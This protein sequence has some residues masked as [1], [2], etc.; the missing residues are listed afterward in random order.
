MKLDKLKELVLFLVAIILSVFI[1]K[2][3]KIFTYL[4]LILGILVPLFVGFIYAWLL[5]PLINKLRKGHKR[6]FICIALFLV[7]ITIILLFFYLL[8]PTIYKEISELSDI[9]PSFFEIIGRKIN[10]LGLREY[11]DRGLAF[12]VDKI[13]L[14]LVNLVKGLFKY[15]GITLVGLILGLY[16]SMDYEKIVKMIDELVPQKFKCIYTNLTKDV[17]T[18]VRKC[19]N[20]TLLVA[21]CVFVMDSILFMI[22]GLD[23]SLLLGILCGITDLIPYIGPYIGGILAVCVGFTESR[24]LGIVTIII[25]VIVQSIENYILQPIVMSKSIKI[26]PVLII[27][28]LLLFGNLFGIVGMILAT[29]IIAIIKVCLEHLK[30]AINKCKE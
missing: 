16:I 21:F 8:I 4:K 19:V 5:N 30:L 23:A 14:Y 17:S 6:N 22:V 11:I 9:L 24:M 2:Y 10:N 1:I 25:C 12:L 3:L 26:S 7:I 29:P 20:G 27:I 13:P 28:G 15:L 18:E